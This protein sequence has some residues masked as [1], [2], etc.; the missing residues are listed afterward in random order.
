MA[1]TTFADWIDHHHPLVS[2]VSGEF[3]KAGINRL[4][5]RELD[6]LVAQ[7]D[8]PQQRT[9]LVRL[10]AF[11]WTGYIDRAARRY[12]SDFDLDE[13]V[14]DVAVKLLM[15]GLFRDWRG[16]PLDRRFKASVKNSLMNMAEKRGNRRRWFPAAQIAP[17]EVAGRGAPH[18]E[19]AIDDFRRLV[20]DRLGPLARA[21]LDVRLDGGDTKALVG[22]PELGEPSSYRIKQTVQGLKALVGQFGDDAFQTMVRRALDRQERTLQRRLSPSARGSAVATG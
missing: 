4:F 16:Q 2:E 13:V 9:E 18:E 17:D 20:R 7:V 14:H 22:A 21:I 8:D 15:G 19:D 3:P 12:F 6:R 5:C 11:D 10:R 1:W